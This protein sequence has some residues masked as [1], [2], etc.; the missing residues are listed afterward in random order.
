MYF[1]RHWRTS[2]AISTR[3]TTEYYTK[4]LVVLPLLRLIYWNSVLPCWFSAY[5]LCSFSAFCNPEKVA[6]N[7]TTMM[8]WYRERPDQPFLWLQL[9]FMQWHLWT[10]WKTPQI[11]INAPRDVY[12]GVSTIY[13]SLCWMQESCI[14]MTSPTISNGTLNDRLIPSDLAHSL[15]CI[16]WSKRILIKSK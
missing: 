14:S 10:S 11:S 8:L 7:L 15:T 16:F 9:F 6:L 5:I 12:L 1:W 4:V 13:L 3:W 2:A